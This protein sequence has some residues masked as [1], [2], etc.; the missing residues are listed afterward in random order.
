M[1]IAI[2]IGA[3]MIGSLPLGLLLGRLFCAFAATRNRA[4][5]RLA[6]P[7]RGRILD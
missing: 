2:G 7:Q 6:A 4:E 3:W 5:E 1:S